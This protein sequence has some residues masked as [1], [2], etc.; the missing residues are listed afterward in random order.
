[1][2]RRDEEN[3]TGK[4]HNGLEMVLTNYSQPLIA[5]LTVLYC[6]VLYCIVLYCIVL[7]CL[8]IVSVLLVCMRIIRQN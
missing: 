1:M 4:T 8:V 2:K 3:S 6:I 5:R 7:S